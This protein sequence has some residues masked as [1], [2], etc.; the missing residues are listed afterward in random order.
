MPNSFTGTSKARAL[1]MQL[2]DGELK[3]AFEGAHYA[4]YVREAEPMGTAANPST[5]GAAPR[6]P[7]WI[8]V[9]FQQ[10]EFSRH[11]LLS[12]RFTKCVMNTPK[13]AERLIITKQVHDPRLL[14]PRG[15]DHDQQLPACSK[16]R[17]AGFEVWSECGQLRRGQKPVL[18]R[19]FAEAAQQRTPMVERTEQMISKRIFIVLPPGSELPLESRQCLVGPS[20]M[21]RQA[22]EAVGR[23]VR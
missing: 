20:P 16:P 1:L 7:S 3:P 23:H 10:V 19:C 14:F 6:T 22:R 2:G 11:S 12:E 17:Q 8:H 13:A 4:L 5:R 21:S 15:R 9:E 18:E